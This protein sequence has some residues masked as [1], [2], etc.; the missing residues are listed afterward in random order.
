MNKL[1]KNPT[2][3]SNIPTPAKN[4]PRL[5]GESQSFFLSIILDTFFLHIIEING[6]NMMR[7]AFYSISFLYFLHCQIY[8]SFSLNDL[9]AACII[10]FVVLSRFI[11]VLYL[12][13]ILSV[14]FQSFGL[15]ILRLMLHHRICYFL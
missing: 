2:P 10:F 12:P 3:N 11:F 14:F 4:I 8:N 9:T 6:L 7:A 5:M 1:R 13:L 15:Q